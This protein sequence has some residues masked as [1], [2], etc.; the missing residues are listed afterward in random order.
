MRCLDT[1]FMIDLF[2]GDDAAR[3]VSIELDTS[4]E[5]VSTAA[6]ALAEFML[7]ANAAGGRYLTRAV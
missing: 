5:S 6:P 1:C 7:G 2:Q 3:T 4:G